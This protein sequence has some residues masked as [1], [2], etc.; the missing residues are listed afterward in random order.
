M[1]NSFKILFSIFL[2]TNT[3]LSFASI[4]ESIAIYNNSKLTSLEKNRKIAFELTKDRFY[5]SATT[6]AK[7]YLAETSS[8][9]AEFEE[10]LQF[11]LFTTGMDSFA[12][13]DLEALKNLNSPTINLIISYK[14]FNK[15]NYQNAQKYLQLIPTKHIFK[16]EAEFLEGVILDLDN[17]LDQAISKYKHCKTIA[18][19]WSGNAYT[20]EQGMFFNKLSDSCTIHMARTY[21]KRRDYKT[22]LKIY[23]TIPKRNYQ[24]PYLLI[25]QAWTNYY[26][27]DYNRALGL[28]VTY[29]SPLLSS[30][31]LPGADVLSALSYHK[32]CL[33]N[34]TALLIDKYQTEYGPKSEAL[35]KQLESQKNSDNYFFNLITRELSANEKDL[36]INKLVLQIS[37]K[38]KFQTEYTAYKKAMV[39]LKFVSTKTNSAF[40]KF[41]KERLTDEVTFRK[42]NLN[43]Y[44]KRYLFQFI[45]DVHKYSYEMFSIKI[46][47][48][49]KRRDLVYEDKKLIS[50]RS[51]GSFENLNRETKQYFWDFRGEFFADE[52]GDYSFGLK[53]NCTEVDNEEASTRRRRR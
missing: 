26:L 9:D 29:K 38:I 16:P 25:E 22:A 41:L 20:K 48:M 33:W 17:K 10:T 37:K 23:K 28:L 53:S 4:K 49:S 27:G 47:V 44:I 21:Y 30:Y 24:W 14:L 6:F 43:Y 40:F 3:F 39:E 32:L 50:D 19:K 52:L 45:N 5:F 7:E 42:V 51:R 18:K 2:L 34:D 35:Q 46:D 31:F 36:Y 15:K 12:N 11:L 8:I 13:L 1:F